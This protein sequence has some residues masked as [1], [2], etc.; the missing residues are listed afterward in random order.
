LDAP[1]ADAVRESRREWPPMLSPLTLLASFPL[2]C[3]FAS[4]S[5][6]PDTTYKLRQI[7]GG[8]CFDSHHRTWSEIISWGR[9]PGCY[10]LIKYLKFLKV[11][12]GR[13]Y[14]RRISS[15]FRYSRYV[16]L[17]AKGRLIWH[18]QTS[19]RALNNKAIQEPKILYFDKFRAMM[20]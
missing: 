17:R 18:S 8:E 7:T 15:I 19:A 16:Y 1:T 14:D 13:C 4:C 10:L 6:H 11:L 3:C 20:T 5:R 9:A 2:D 12:D